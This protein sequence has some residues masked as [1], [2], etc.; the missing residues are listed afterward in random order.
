M[1]Q[2]RDWLKSNDKQNLQ[3]FDLFI[4]EAAELGVLFVGS[5]VGLKV[6]IP[7]GGLRIVMEPYGWFGTLYFYYYSGQKT[8]L[9]LRF[10]Q[11]ADM[12][13]E[14]DDAAARLQAFLD[15]IAGIPELATAADVLRSSGCSRRPNIPLTVLSDRSI[16]ELVGA[17]RA[18]LSGGAR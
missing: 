4:S 10:T 3:K 15:L 11:A 7:A 8:S 6:S 12:V 18:L 17:L 1:E 5:D 14:N 9:E 16:T 2:Y 13:S